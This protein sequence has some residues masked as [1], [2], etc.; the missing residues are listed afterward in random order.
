M[1]LLGATTKKTALALSLIFALVILMNFRI[2][3]IDD[4]ACSGSLVVT[5]DSPQDKVY[6]LHNVVISISASD[7]AMLTG[8]ESLAYSLDG[9][10]QVIIATAPLG[11]HSL[12]G[13]VVFSLPNGRHEIVGIGIT[14]FNGTTDGIFYSTPVYFTVD[15]SIDYVPTPIPTPYNEPQS[16]ELEVILGVA[17]TVAVLVAGLG[18]LIYLIKRK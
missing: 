18:L 2:Y 14:W 5:V 3:F 8:P 7:P 15:S 13:S 6:T 1:L 4:A 11:M 10:P 9:G 16:T 17:I 12:N